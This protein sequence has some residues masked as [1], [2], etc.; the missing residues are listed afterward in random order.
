MSEDVK[1]ARA[2][3]ARAWKRIEDFD[4][5]AREFVNSGAYQVLRNSQTEGEETVLTFTF[6]VN[7][8]VPIELGLT[9]GEVV[10]QLRSTLDNLTTALATFHKLPKTH[11]LTFPVFLKDS[12]Q[13]DGGPNFTAWSRK[14]PFN[15]ALMKFFH[16]VQPF[17]QCKGPDGTVT[18]GESTPLYIVNKLWAKEKHDTPLKVTAVNPNTTVNT[19]GTSA[20]GSAKGGTM[21]GTSGITY[22]KDG[23][24]R[25]LFKAEFSAGNVIEDGIEYA[26]ITV[27]IGYPIDQI[28]APIAV[29]ITVD[30]RAPVAQGRPVAPLLVELHHFTSTLVDSLATGFKKP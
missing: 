8:S 1:I 3:L 9:C 21:V 25:T 11:G 22:T 14:Y 4:R 6:K 19:G 5:E 29:Q 27:P 10:N 24:E 26:R 17:N 18:V 28:Q 23:A 20:S 13:N 7:R 12:I 30:E 16:L 15:P 2:R